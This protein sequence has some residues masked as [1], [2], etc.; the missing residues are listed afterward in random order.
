MASEPTL[1]IVIYDPCLITLE[2]FV[3]I[4]GSVTLFSHYGQKGILIIGKVS[5]GAK[6]TIGLKAS[7]MGDVKIGRGVF[8]PPHKVILPKTSIDDFEK[9]T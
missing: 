8:I 4:G 2:D 1:S 9:V 5:I 7:V 6:T 3:T